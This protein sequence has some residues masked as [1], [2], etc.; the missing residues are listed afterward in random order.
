MACRDPRS[1]IPHYQGMYPGQ[2][3]AESVAITG[4]GAVENGLEVGAVSRILWL[5]HR[6]NRPV[7]YTADG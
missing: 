2:H 6:R 7:R 3:R 4:N 5:I 1:A